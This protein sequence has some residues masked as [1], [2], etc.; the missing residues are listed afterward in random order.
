MGGDEK[1]LL[2]LG[3][4]TLLTLVSERLAEQVDQLALNANGDA[5]RFAGFG[6]D[7]FADTMNGFQGPL[8]GVLAGMRWAQKKNLSDKIITVATD[9][10]FFPLKYVDQ[11]LAAANGN[12]IVLASSDGRR[13]PVF[14]LWDISL[15][16]DLEQFL[17]S[18]DRKVMLFV[19]QYTNTC[20]EFAIEPFDPF[21]N[22]NTPEELE[23]AQFLLK[24]QVK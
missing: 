15:A 13:H 6:L 1:S 11:M 22:V 4:K 8:A 2:S 5:S 23:R 17:L 3:S 24:E 18:G 16:D 20:V 7:V 10:P 21:F 19:Q 12:R 9:T 14:G